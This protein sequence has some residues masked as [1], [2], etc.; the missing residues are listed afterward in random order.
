MNPAD[1]CIG[2]RFTVQDIEQRLNTAAG[3]YDSSKFTPNGG[4]VIVEMFWQH[5]PLF[6]GPIFQGTTG[7]PEND[8]V[9][10]IYGIFPTVAAEPTATPG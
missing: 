10:Y 3:A 8:P 5:H 9:L 7:N 6:L 2:S 1:G 4:M